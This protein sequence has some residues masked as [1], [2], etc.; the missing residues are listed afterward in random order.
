MTMGDIDRDEYQYMNKT[1]SRDIYTIL[2]DNARLNRHNQTE[3]ES[4]L[5]EHLRNGSLGH[6]FR[7]QH[8]I[9]DFIVDFVCLKKNLVIEVDGDYHKNPEQ[10]H[11]DNVRSEMLYRRGFY[12]LRFTN[13]EVLQSIE[14][15]LIRIK[16][17]LDSIK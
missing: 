15:V 16:E 1:S 10:I 13:E 3:A 12:V 9:Y 14:Y 8:P 6:K 17:V 4:F 7:R 11:D 2:E 5:W